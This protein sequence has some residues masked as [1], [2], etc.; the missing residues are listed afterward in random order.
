MPGSAVSDWIAQ[1][2]PEWIRQRI[3]HL[4]AS[5]MAAAMSFT[6]SGADSAERRKLKIDILTERL[7]D[8]AVEHY[9]SAAMQWGIDNEPAARSA[10]EDSTGLIVMPAGF[11]VHPSIEFFGA[12]PD[13]LVGSDALFEAKC[14]TTQTHLQWMLAGV[15]PD[16]YTPQMTAQCA[17][18]GRRIVHFVSFDP[19]LPERQRLFYRTFSPTEEQIAQVEEAARKLLAEVDAMFEKITAEAA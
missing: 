11:V 12:S 13:G 16:E 9:V 10:F 5:R 17:C 3:G 1:G 18:T 6:K 19:R 15:V 4:T 2:S 14:P 7:A 8:A